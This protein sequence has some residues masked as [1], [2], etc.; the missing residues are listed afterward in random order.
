M[1]VLIA[2]AANQ[3]QVKRF[4]DNLESRGFKIVETEY[5]TPSA[6]RN[7]RDESSG[8]HKCTVNVGCSEFNN[9]GESFYEYTAW[10]DTVTEDGI[11]GEPVM[12]QASNSFS[13]TTQDN[14]RLTRFVYFIDSILTQRACVGDRD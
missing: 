12:T 11:T 7:Y 9:G 14:E 6:T 3:N 4:F 13:M 2:L 10:V 5:G 1:E 8:N